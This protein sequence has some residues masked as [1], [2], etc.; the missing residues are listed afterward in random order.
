MTSKSFFNGKDILI[1]GASSG[2][3]RATALILA[4]LGSKVV[5]ASRNEARLNQLRDE[6]VSKGGEALVVKTDVCQYCDTE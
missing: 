2:I 3:G 5:L 4:Q 6:I 1:T